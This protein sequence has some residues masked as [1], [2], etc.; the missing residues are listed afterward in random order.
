[1]VNARSAAVS[2][3]KAAWM[4]KTVAG[5][6]RFFGWSVAWDA[7]ALLVFAAGVGRA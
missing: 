2:W 4:S 3:R 7:F 5:R 1:M 6:K